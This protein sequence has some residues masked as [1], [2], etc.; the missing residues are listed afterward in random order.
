MVDREIFFRRPRRAQC[1][2]RASLFRSLLPREGEVQMIDDVLKNES[3]RY[4]RN[5]RHV[6]HGALK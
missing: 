3:G 5:D 4:V 2:A 6:S 1:T